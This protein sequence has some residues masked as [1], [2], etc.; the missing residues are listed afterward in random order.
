MPE[1]LAAMT[2]SPLVTDNARLP[3]TQPCHDVKD[4]PTTSR[5]ELDEIGLKLEALINDHKS[6]P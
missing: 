3:Q 5:T 4:Q 1:L 6:R 2:S